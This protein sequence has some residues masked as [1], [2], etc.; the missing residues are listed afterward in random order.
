MCAYCRSHANRATHTV[1]FLPSCR[2]S[3]LTT[4]S[5]NRVSLSSTSVNLF[6][7]SIGSIGIWVAVCVIFHNEVGAGV[8]RLITCLRQDFETQN[9]VQQNCARVPNSAKTDSRELMCSDCLDKY[10]DARERDHREH[11]RVL[12][13]LP[14]G[15]QFPVGSSYIVCWCRVSFKPARNDIIKPGT[16]TLVRVASPRPPEGP[17]ALLASPSAGGTRVLRSRPS[18]RAQLL[19]LPSNHLRSILRRRLLVL[20]RA[21]AESALAASYSRGRGAMR[22]SGSPRVTHLPGLSCI[23]AFARLPIPNA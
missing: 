23:R 12:I 16:L 17:I 15:A 10:S 13:D 2:L 19:S 18:S 3:C 4:W 1:V 9:P 6:L 20:R 14:R 7:V 5:R 21:S 8:S 22:G 11:V